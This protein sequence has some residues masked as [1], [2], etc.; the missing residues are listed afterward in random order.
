M[1]IKLFITFLVMAIAV[2]GCKKSADNID[3]APLEIGE[4]KNH[5]VSLAQAEK[6]SVLHS[7][8]PENLSASSKKNSGTSLLSSKTIV[9]QQPK[10]EKSVKNTFSVKEGQTNAT[11]YVINYNEGGYIIVSGDDR[12]VPILAHSDKGSF[13]MTEISKLPNGLRQWFSDN[14]NYILD[15]RSGKSNDFKRAN[16]TKS[17]WKEFEYKTALKKGNISTL[18]IPT[19]GALNVGELYYSPEEYGPYMITN[20]GQDVGFND[21]APSSPYC[22]S[23]RN[24]RAPIGCVAVAMG[25]VMYYHQSPSRYN[26]SIMP[27]D[28]GSTETS[29]MLYDAALSVNMHWGSCDGS[30]AW[31]SNIEEGLEDDFGYSAT[32]APYNFATV[33]T[34]ISFGSPVILGADRSLLQGHAWA[35]S[36]VKKNESL[37]CTEVGD[38]PPGGG[39]EQSKVRGITTKGVPGATYQWVTYFDNH[40]LY[41]HWGYNSSIDGWY[42]AYTWSIFGN[43]YAYNKDMVTG[44]TP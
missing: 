28:V 35:A 11:A 36:G 5:M 16:Y 8:Y 37:I 15:L 38:I 12:M 32:T 31:F 33:F 29:T 10:S 4:I 6:V 21:L 40:Q 22:A 30:W 1:K 39:G 42:S 23:W 27:T 19:C 24:Y 3:D 9:A 41:M 13:E 34:N 44:I 14:H 26:W 2:V 18:T 17:L 20:W 7:I 43:T 25:Q